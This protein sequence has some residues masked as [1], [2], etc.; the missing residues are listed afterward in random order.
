MKH[1]AE[2]G[3]LGKHACCCGVEALV[4]SYETTGHGPAT[5]MRKTG[6]AHEHGSQFIGLA[7]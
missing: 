7:R 4:E 2:P 1:V 6:P 3:F 5:A